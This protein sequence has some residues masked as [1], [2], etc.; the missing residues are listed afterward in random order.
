MTD[1]HYKAAIAI[2]LGARSTGLFTVVHPANRFPT[3]ADALTAAVLVPDDSGF[4]AS[5]KSRT[6]RRHVIRSKKRYAMARRLVTSLFTSLF[7]QN[8]VRL[9]G[10]DERRFL[11]ALYGLLKRRGYTW[12]QAEDTDTETN[13]DDFDGFF[14]GAI[15]ALSP[16]F[17]EGRSLAEEWDVLSQNRRKGGICP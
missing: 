3:K 17:H 14:L 4:T 5:Q 6:M 15:P 11:M 2:D 1:N 8:G 13:L 12:L 9:S 10:K 16:Y 7:E